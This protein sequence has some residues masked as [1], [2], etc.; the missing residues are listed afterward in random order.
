MTNEQVRTVVGESFTEY[1]D[2]KARLAVAQHLMNR[3][4][5][6]LKRIA[7]SLQT[8]PSTVQVEELS[9]IPNLRNIQTD[10]LEA[11]NEVRELHTV[12]VNAGVG[13]LLKD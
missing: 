5:A 3:A 13:H 6:T 4:A 12:L 11:S 2:A 8:D 9:I 1:V 10:Y 7:Q